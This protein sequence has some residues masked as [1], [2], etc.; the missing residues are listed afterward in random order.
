MHR[1]NDLKTICKSW[2]SLAGYVMAIFPHC[3]INYQIYSISFFDLK[4]FLRYRTCQVAKPRRQHIEKIE[5]YRTL[6]LV[7]SLVSRISSSLFLMNAK[8]CTIDSLMSSSLLSSTSRGLSL[9]ASP[10]L[11]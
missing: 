9:A 2:G 7:D 1:I 5:K 4:Y 10:T 6:L 8:S 11:S 3:E